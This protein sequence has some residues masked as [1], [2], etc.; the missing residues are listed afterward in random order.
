MCHTEVSLTRHVEPGCSPKVEQAGR[1]L[2]S[3]H[4]LSTAPEVRNTLESQRFNFF[5]FQQGFLLRPGRSAYQQPAGSQDGVEEVYPPPSDAQQV[6]SKDALLKQSKI[7]AGIVGSPR[8]AWSGPPCCVAGAIIPFS[9]PCP[10]CWVDD[11]HPTS[12]L[13]PIA[14][15][16]VGF[17]CFPL[18]RSPMEAQRRPW[19]LSSSLPLLSAM[20]PQQSW[21]W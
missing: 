20:P 5:P 21:P 17:A 1:W 15:E 13:V 9:I 3:F 6:N 8:Q 7:L 10:L 14:A 19:G 2:L 16:G 18:L 12:M 4:P 11:T